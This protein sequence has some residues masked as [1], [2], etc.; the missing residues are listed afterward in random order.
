MKDKIEQIKFTD[1]RILPLYGIKSVQDYVT[2]VS[3]EKV[4]NDKNIINNLNNI[5]PEIKEVYPM[6]DFNLH[7]T[8]GKILTHTQTYAF[9]KTC[10]NICNIPYEICKKNKINY[11]RLSQK[12]I[13]L[14]NY[15][16][17]HL[18]S[19][20]REN[21]QIQ[22]IKEKE[23]MPY[24][25]LCSSV[26]KE[27]IQDYY[28]PTSKI[29][30]VHGGP[31]RNVPNGFRIGSLERVLS[32]MKSL[33]L[34]II[35]SNK[36]EKMQK[37]CNDFFYGL[38]YNL[39]IGGSTIYEGVLQDGQNLFPD[40]IYPFSLCKYHEVSITIFCDETIIDLFRDIAQADIQVQ[41]THV[42][43]TQ[44]CRKKLNKGIQFSPDIKV[45]FQDNFLNFSNWCVNIQYSSINE[46][47]K[48]IKPKQ[49]IDF[50][51]DIEGE[52]FT[53]GKYK[54]Y[55]V[56]DSE[57]KNSCCTDLI[58][59]LCVGYDICVQKVTCRQLNCQY[60]TKSGSVY[61][62]THNFLRDCDAISNISMTLPPHILSVNGYTIAIYGF[63]LDKNGQLEKR[64]IFA[65]PHFNDMKIQEL[66]LNVGKDNHYLPMTCYGTTMTFKVECDQIAAH[67]IMKNT[68]LSYDV[69]LA[70]TNIRQNIISS[71]ND[72]VLE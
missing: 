61:T 44:A 8:E 6:K 15:I 53:A 50:M 19:D 1:T 67:D 51:K 55:R 16:N 39:D 69:L 64:E 26:K 22:Q 62:F 52:E 40:Q 24:E 59:V 48:E 32:D 58:K 35:S 34:S 57:Y 31:K 33:T 54:C 60:Y 13:I 23:T 37:I 11:V 63:D 10:L 71:T 29:G 4:Q 20:I 42:K 38:K 9:L 65:T 27:Y 56:A 49:E 25:E 28:F 72:F 70:N 30:I 5:L 45:P 14:E 17:T 7:K 41:I 18:M 3:L 46:N 47:L 68:M 66:K 43:F 21:L 12:N 2:Q 36:V